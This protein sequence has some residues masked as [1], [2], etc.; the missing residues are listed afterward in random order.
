MSIPT[1]PETVI[2]KNI[3]Y[4][5][6]LTEGDVWNYYMR[7]KG[8]ILTNT[9]G[10][11]LMVAIMVNVNRPILRRKASIDTPIRLTNSNYSTLL[12]GRTVS[13]YSTIK[14]YEDFVV[15]DIDTEEWDKAINVT[16]VVYD[17]MRK[18]NFVTSV[19]ILYTGK[20]SFHLHCKISNKLPINTINSI[21]KEHLRQNQNQTMFTLLHKRS[22]N[23]PNID[24]SPNKYKG[25]F[26]TEGSLSIWGLKCM[27]IPINQLKSFKMWK[28]K[29]I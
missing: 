14:A 4:P 8:I 2:I 23:L 15:V 24:L 28:A 25:A 18:A 26:I 29:I 27:E 17:I 5:D 6:G 22:P 21:T 10:R 11:D 13:I 3:M 12:T 20:N 19:K 16:Q 9:R 7:Y 1:N